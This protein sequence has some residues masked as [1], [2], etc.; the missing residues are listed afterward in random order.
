MA[1]NK[2]LCAYK[3]GGYSF[4]ISRAEVQSSAAMNRTCLLN[5]EMPLMKPAKAHSS[6]MQ[7]VSKQLRHL[8]HARLILYIEQVCYYMCLFLTIF[9]FLMP[10][11][12][13]TIVFVLVFRFRF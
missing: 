13:G 5:M 9:H 4:G 7:F 6:G 3:T 2:Y 10:V 8:L 11:I 1:D 12:V